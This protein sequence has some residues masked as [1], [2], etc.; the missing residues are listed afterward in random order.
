MRRQSLLVA[1]MALLAIFAGPAP[2]QSSQPDTSTQ[3][4]KEFVLGNGVVRDLGPADGSLS[5]STIV[6]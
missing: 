3:I 6:A 4:R 2:G 5:D 1:C